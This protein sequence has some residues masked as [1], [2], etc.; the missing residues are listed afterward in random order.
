MGIPKSFYVQVTNIYSKMSYRTKIEAFMKW[1]HKWELHITIY[2]GVLIAAIITLIVG[3]LPERGF[4]ALVII[5][6]SIFALAFVLIVSDISYKYREIQIS[7]TFFSPMIVQN[8]EESII[9]NKNGSAHLNVRRLITFEEEET[10]TSIAQDYW[11]E[12]AG[13]DITCT[14]IEV[15][16]KEVIL[17]PDNKKTITSQSTDGQQ[18]KNLKIEIP[19]FGK[20]KAFDLICQLEFPPGAF[21]KAM[22]NRLDYFDMRIYHPTRSLRMSIELNKDLNDQY[23]LDTPSFKI[24]DLNGNRI[25]LLEVQLRKS[26]EV[27]ICR[28]GKKISW[29]LT[30]PKNGLNYQLKFRIFS[31]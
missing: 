27:P 13:E 8:Q 11:A 6:I 20:K 5:L 30:A 4:L 16:G 14:S 3:Y 22:N 10:T 24:V 23:R 25:G 2:L 15:N 19:I 1:T 29:E 12:T 18:Y 26:G 17:N 7:K 9:I 28:R 21:S 31:S